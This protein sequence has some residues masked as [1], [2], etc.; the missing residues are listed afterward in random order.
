MAFLQRA[1]NVDQLTSQSKAKRGK[2]EIA[3]RQSQEACTMRD[4]ALNRIGNYVHES[5]PVSN[6]EAGALRL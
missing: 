4:I 1:E 3:L 6:D 5:V 2:I